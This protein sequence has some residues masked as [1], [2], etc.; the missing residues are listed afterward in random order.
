MSKIKP[1]QALGM[2]ALTAFILY[3]VASLFSLSVSMDAWNWFS[4]ILFWAP[5]IVLGVWTM[6]DYFINPNK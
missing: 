3:L 4:K 6:N 5:T 1:F 2:W